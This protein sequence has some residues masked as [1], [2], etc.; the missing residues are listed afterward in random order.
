MTSVKKEINDL[1]CGSNVYIKH[2]K[3]DKIYKIPS[4]A[5]IPF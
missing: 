5:A 1:L 2:V 3:N 4:T